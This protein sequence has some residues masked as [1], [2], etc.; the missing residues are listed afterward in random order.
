MAVRE[1]TVGEWFDEPCRGCVL[2]PDGNRLEEL[3]DGKPVQ[4]GTTMNKEEYDAKRELIYEEYAAK[5]KLIDE[6][7]RA[8]CKLI[9]DEF[10]AEFYQLRRDL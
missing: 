8:K 10:Y 6:E 9:E 2:H 3:G 1:W 7:Y 4:E 5:R